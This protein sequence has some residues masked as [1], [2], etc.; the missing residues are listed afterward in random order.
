MA[1]EVEIK[2]H[3]GESLKEKID[4]YTSQTGEE[5]IKEDTY[6]AFDGDEVPR[7]RI[8]R[9]NDFLLISAKRNHR[10]GGLECNEELEFRHDNTEDQ[11]VMEDM[12]ALLRKKDAPLQP[13]RCLAP[14]ARLRRKRN[15][16]DPRNSQAPQRQFFLPVLEMD[17]S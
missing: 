13:A 15:G 1:Y 6:Y 10:E 3:A 8:R 12:A 7:F 17:S 2:A 14:A 9:E 11:R 4:A 16:N 5:V